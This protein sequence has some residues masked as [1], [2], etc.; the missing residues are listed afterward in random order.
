[1]KLNK[2]ACLMLVALFSFASCDGVEKKISNKDGNNLSIEA[3][4]KTNEHIKEMSERDSVGAL[5]TLKTNSETKKTHIVSSEPIIVSDLKNSYSIDLKTNLDLEGLRSSP[6]DTSNCT[7]FFSTIE[8]QSNYTANTGVVEKENVNSYTLENNNITYS[9]LENSE[10]HVITQE[11]S[12][13]YAKTILSVLETTSFEVT[14]EMSID[15]IEL[16]SLQEKLNKKQISAQEYVDY[17]D[18]NFLNN[19]LKNTASEKNYDIVVDIVEHSAETSPLSFIEYSKIKQ[20]TNTTLIGE[21]NYTKW[22][23]SL[24]NYLANCPLLLEAFSVPAIDYYNNLLDT[25]LPNEI[26]LNFSISYNYKDIITGA[27]IEYYS[28]EA[29]EFSSTL[30]VVEETMFS[31][32][33]TLAISKRK[34]SI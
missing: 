3:I 23:D 24:V 1:M 30:S 15:I 4:K 9:N 32:A 10:T 29:E 25:S 34:I 6:V 2:L 5:F 19:T 11:E 18:E 12:E 31:A 33:V 14:D 8:Q 16:L 20:S 27:S 21:F 13:Y 7:L 22:K 28:K 26:T 17:I